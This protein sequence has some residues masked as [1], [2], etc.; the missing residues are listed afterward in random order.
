MGASG[1]IGKHYLIFFNVDNWKNHLFIA[2]GLGDE[3]QVD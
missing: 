2:Q 1:H 3:N